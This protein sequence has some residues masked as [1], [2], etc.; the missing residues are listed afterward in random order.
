MGLTGGL[1]RMELMVAKLSKEGAPS[2]PRCEKFNP[3]GNIGDKMDFE[4]GQRGL[5]D[6]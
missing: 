6:D 1:K 2:P 5:I 3:F 4:K